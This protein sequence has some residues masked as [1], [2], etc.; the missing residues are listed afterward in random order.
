MVDPA[1]LHRPALPVAPAVLPRRDVEIAALPEGHV[2]MVSARKGAVVPA[3]ALARL[4]SGSPLAV[5]PVGPGQ[6]LVVG[7]APL[8]PADVA[9]RGAAL[10]GAAGLF[11]LGHGRVRIAIRGAGAADLLATGVAIDLDGLPVGGSAACLFRHV[12]VHLTRTDTQ[13]FE[14]IV[15]RSFAADLWHELTA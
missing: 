5:R 6:W 12:A 8:S 7:D 9:D 15:A 2:L 4:G 1:S 10:A 13:A 11:D 14:L 3:D